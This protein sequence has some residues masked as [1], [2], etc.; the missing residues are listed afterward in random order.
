M[1]G[2]SEGLSLLDI[3]RSGVST[4]LGIVFNLGWL[5]ATCRC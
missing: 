5:Q 4:A 3:I 2:P 1:S